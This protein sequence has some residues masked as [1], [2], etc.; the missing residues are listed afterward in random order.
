MKTNKKARVYNSPIVDSILSNISK[1][2]SS[3]ASC[4]YN[5]DKSSFWQAI[6]QNP[7]FS[8]ILSPKSV[9]ESL[10]ST[11]F[12]CDQFDQETFSSFLRSACPLVK[13]PER[14]TGLFIKLI[15]SEVIQLRSKAIKN[16]F[17]LMNSAQLSKSNYV[18]NLVVFCY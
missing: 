4:N 2:V 7:F 9:F 1:V 12:E 17:N 3:D 15:S 13:I 11:I 10:N 5:H 6:G 18:K 14:V 8:T 16:L